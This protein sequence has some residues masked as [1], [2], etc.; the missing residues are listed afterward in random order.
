MNELSTIEMAIEVVEV[1]EEEKKKIVSLEVQQIRFKEK[2]G[3]DFQKFYKKFFPKLTY[4]LQSYCKD[5]EMATDITCEAFI[6][7][8]E[9]I[10]KYNPEKAGFSTWLFTIARNLTLQEMKKSNRFTSID[11]KIDEGGTSIKDFLN[12]NSEEDL[13]T[14]EIVELTKK[15]SKI[16]LNAI[17]KLKPQYRDVIIMREIDKMSYKDIAT[18]MGTNVDINISVK[19]NITN[20]PFDISGVNNINSGITYKLLEGNKTLS[21]F[22]TKIVVPNGNYTINVRKPYNINTLKSKI[23]NSRIML[24]KAVKRDFELLDKMYL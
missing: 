20:L 12:D 6:K 4:Y 16:M 14:Q 5:H 8:L 15:K 21:P 2:T 11:Q 7:G 22:F 13:K 19:N 18:Q 10:E 24:Q 17:N 1:V 23:R 3:Q 9:E